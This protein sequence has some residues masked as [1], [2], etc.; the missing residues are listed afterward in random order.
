M[1]LFHT[2]RLC[3]F[4]TRLGSAGAGETFHS[5]ATMPEASLHLHECNLTAVSLGVILTRGGRPVRVGRSTVFQS[6]LKS[7]VNG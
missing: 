3:N 4:K 5:R 1:P 2:G 6:I 7:V